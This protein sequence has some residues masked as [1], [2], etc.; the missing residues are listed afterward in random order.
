MHTE[1][2]DAIK[3]RTVVV[4]PYLALMGLYLG[5]FTGI[6]LLRCEH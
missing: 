4:H 1:H 3:A 5:G 2:H 6:Y